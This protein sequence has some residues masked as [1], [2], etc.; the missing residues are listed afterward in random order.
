[1]R[2][3]SKHKP[4]RWLRVSLSLVVAVLAVVVS[5]GA[6]GQ[7]CNV[8]VV[9]DANPDYCDIGSFIYSATSN[10]QTPEEK[11][12]AL[13]YWNH[14]AR[15]QTQPMTLH[16]MELADPIM[17]FN[18]YGYTMCSTISGMN[19]AIWGAMGYGVKFW[20][21][22][23]HTVPEV[24]YGGRYHMYDNSMSAIY[25]LCDGKTIAGVVDIG[26]EGAC[27][28]SGGKVEPAHVAR[29]HCLNATS[30]NGFLTGA[31]D[32]R[33][34][35][36]EARC[37]KTS[38]LKYRYYYNSWDLGH[39]YILNLREGEAYTRYYHRLDAPKNDTS[40]KTEGAGKFTSDPAYYV[41]NP[42]GPEGKDPEAVNPRYRLRGNGLR[43]FMPVLSAG[44]LE[45]SV[46]SM[47]GVKAAS[48]GLTPARARQ[49]GE[50]VFAVEG[51]NVITNVK[52]KAVFFRKTGGDV[53][54]V[55]IS[56][57][58]GIKWQ[59]VW[60]NTGL[61]ETPVELNLTNEVNGAYIVLVRVILMGA[62]YAADAT[63]KS[64]SFETVTAL[65]SKTQPMLRLGKNTV[66]VGAGEKTESI[67]LWPEL[68]ADRYKD[69]IVEEHNVASDK[70]HSGWHGVLYPAK[71]KEDGWVV[72]RIDAPAD[73]TRLT[74][75]GRF[76]NRA[77][78]S[79][80]DLLYSTDGGKTWA[81]SWS[82]TDT[83]PPWDTI[84]YEKVEMPKGCGS[85][86]VKY[87]INSGD[88]NETG[89][90]AS[91]Y[92]VR[93]EADY[94]P[95]DPQ[96]TALGITF[97]W[98]ERQDDYTTVERRHWQLVRRAELPY[99]Y[100]INVGG[101]DDPIVES[102][103]V[104]AMPKHLTDWADMKRSGYSDG[105]DVGGEKFVGRWET[106][107]TNFAL[108]RPYTV[109]VPTETNWGAGDPEN[110]VL[111]DG[112]V[113][114]TYVGGNSYKYGAI[115]SNPKEPV[116]TV[117]LGETRSC[118]AFR[119]QV[120]GYPWWDATAGEVKDKVEVLTS[121][122][123]REYKSA[124]FV[125]FRLRWKDIPVNYLWPQD[126][127]NCGYNFP[128]VLEKPVEARYVQFRL[129][130]ARIMSVSEVQALDF[131]RYEPFD[132]KVALP[133]G[134]DR[135]DITAYLP[136]HTESRPYSAG[137]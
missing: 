98:R 80:A 88:V 35:A 112:V 14:T 19:C 28:K 134:K 127:R 130:P 67:I 68:Q 87:L 78:G 118:G 9:T 101:V 51:A 103:S 122:D 135:S 53:T 54:S 43:V 110:K 76:Y 36:E 69:L 95:A 47:S 61:G 65:N 125:N 86:L 56:T 40:T 111:T 107:G 60:T 81:K 32:I 136:K 79:H 7:V 45:R 46:Y 97:T 11:C 48:D 100:V 21:I 108:G 85:V 64:I 25:T 117:D 115:W 4:S 17:Q 58:N 44:Y 119:I 34:L 116:I 12:R 42:P 91:I 10:W 137:R 128:L 129:T 16:G 99:V 26:A 71:S 15:R 27:E 109:S 132:L 23:L 94:R 120:G 93:M 123:G 90:G 83:T 74:Y 30:P 57:S 102:L 82:L 38:A 106:E 124:G 49:P 92:A 13:F 70:A 39:R 29:W 96:F 75:G 59:E 72:Y 84:N 62:G 126:E 2:D 6:K 66:F 3:I 31:D 114:P 1:M 20:D 133:D 131:I 18:D 8:K 63:L 77:P 5:A 73:I 37:F 52:I 113:G 105:K 22:T 41:P 33:S 121:T 24:E 55:A 50:V 89:H 104:Y